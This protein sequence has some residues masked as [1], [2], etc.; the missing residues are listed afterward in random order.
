MRTKCISVPDDCSILFNKI[1][2]KYGRKSAWNV[3]KLLTSNEFS[4]RIETLSRDTEGFPL[5]EDIMEFDEVLYMIGEDSLNRELLKRISPVEFSE[6]NYASMIESVEKELEGSAEKI[7][8]YIEEDENGNIYPVLKMKNELS[9]KKFVEQK[10][11]HKLNKALSSM[12]EKQGI[13]YT[14]LSDEERKAGRIGVADLTNAESMANGFVSLIRIAK[15]VEGQ[16]ALSEEFSH[17]IIASLRNEPVIDRFIN[18]LSQNDDALKVILGDEYEDNVRFHNGDNLL[19]AEEALGKLLREGLLE[20][21]NSDPL[22]ERVSNLIKGKYKDK[23]S[24][25]VFNLIIEAEE[26]MRKLSDSILAGK[27]NITQDKI[28]E[29]KHRNVQFNALSDRLDRAMDILTNAKDV[30]RKRQ[31]ITGKWN[32]RLRNK[33]K[34]LIDNI[35]I[36]EADELKLTTGLARYTKSAFDNLSDIHKEINV[37]NTL[38]LEKRFAL[39]KRLK[40][41]LDSYAEFIRDVSKEM[42]SSL[43]SETEHEKNLYKEVKIKNDNDEDE[44]VDIPDLVQKLNNLQTIL[45][46][47]YVDIARKTFATFIEPFFGSQVS[48]NGK[49]YDVNTIISGADKDI[50]FIDAMLCAAKDSNNLLIQTFDRVVSLKNNEIREETIK[51]SHRIQELNQRAESMGIT[52]FSF[53]YETYN[54]KK[55]GNYVSEINFGKFDYEFNKFMKELDEEYE[56]KTDFADQIEKLN[57]KKQWIKENTVNGNIANPDPEKYKGDYEKLSSDE[58]KIFEEYLDIKRELDSLYPGSMT[59]TYKAIQKRKTGGN[60]LIESIKHPDKMI[61]NLK[62]SI[63]E[64]FY[65]SETD[66]DLFGEDI[67]G[68]RN[69]DGTEF[70]LVPVLYTTPLKNPDDISTDAFSSLLAYAYSAVTYEKMT[71]IVN[72]LETAMSLVMDSKTFK[73]V[74]TVGDRSKVEDVTDGVKKYLAKDNSY[75]T[76]RLRD[77]MNSNVYLRYIKDEG[78]FSYQNSDG[79]TRTVSYT[80]VVNSFLRASSFAKMGFNFLANISNITTGICMAHIEMAAGKYFT[81]KEMA[82]ADNVYRKMLKNHLTNLGSRY[83]TDELSLLDDL[84]DIKQTYGNRVKYDNKKKSWMEKVFGSTFAF[85]GQEAGDHWLY[86]RVAL[87]HLSHIKVLV[88][89]S[90][91]NV[92]KIRGYEKAVEIVKKI[93]ED[94]KLYSLTE[95]EKFY[96]DN[97]HNKSIRVTQ[98]IKTSTEDFSEKHEDGSPN[99]YILPSTKIGTG[100]D[101]LVRDFFDDN[102]KFVFSNGEFFVQKNGENI[103]LSDIYPNSTQEDLSSFVRQLNTLKKEFEDNGL[104]IVSKDVVAQGF[105]EVMVGTEM[106]KV[107]VAGTLDLLAYDKDGNFHIFDMKTHRGK[108][109]EGKKNKWSKQTTLYA[110][111]LEEKYGINV[112][113]INIIPI[114]VEYDTPIGEES[115]GKKG[116]A[117][118]KAD[119]FKDNQLLVKDGENW[120]EFTGSKPKLE[121]IIRLGRNNKNIDYVILDEESRKIVDSYNENIDLG[122]YV[123]MSLLDAIEYKDVFEGNNKIRKAYIP[124]GTRYTNEGNRYVTVSEISDRIKAIN[125]KLYGIYNQADQNA[126]NQVAIGRILQQMRKWVVPLL[127]ARFGSMRRDLTLNEDFEG[128]YRTVLRLVADIHNGKR[129]LSYW[130]ILTGKGELSDMEAENIARARFEILQFLAVSMLIWFG[131]WKDKKN[132]SAAMALAEYMARRTQHE[133]GTLVPSTTFANE[134]VKTFKNP[135]LIMSDLEAISN[136]ASSILTPSDWTTEIKTGPNKGLTKLEKSM[137]Y[138][139]FEPAVYMRAYRKYG[140][141]FIESMANSIN[142]YKQ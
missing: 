113:S 13:T 65:Y 118:Y 74:D 52:D 85:I 61:S 75:I 86:N 129:N 35:D 31:K 117:E 95:D 78:G 77:Y 94:S 139:S 26:E 40:D 98:A 138:T 5:L 56:D 119:E 33:I 107:P 50:S 100:V 115:G 105:M 3:Y 30:E 16:N 79:E 91:R 108:S 112:K 64:A 136:C 69:F 90:S 122:N 88:P 68:M 102:I 92:Q 109:V 32:S 58:K 37:I 123:E 80:K 21:V 4:K 125:H 62:E 43:N 99:N 131:P 53:M 24:N 71:S 39:L 134:W 76:K 6:E 25:D 72:P 20:G 83:K 10:T 59:N 15:G 104:T 141:E 9:D 18:R 132:R 41:Y 97:A 133:L 42:D 60:R 81:A 103:K 140:P 96:E 137:L 54:G 128:Y 70:M 47:E 120:A 46:A 36:S 23:D 7:S 11:A 114:K 84:F 135:A 116:T 38:S 89:K 124:E 12:F 66:K 55:T 57:K 51:Y 29:M 27:L 44:L 87:A 48:I 1:V 8:I 93:T 67:R 19:I 63:N 121:S 73:V 130:S 45:S 126:A 17:V 14:L 28:R 22:I 142:Y 34:F 127:D 49:M 101:I 110:K 111:F 106:K 82:H 2:S